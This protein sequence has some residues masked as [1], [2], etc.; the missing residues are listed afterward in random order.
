MYEYLQEMCCNIDQN[1]QPF[2]PH[3]AVTITALAESGRK[4][5]PLEEAKAANIYIYFLL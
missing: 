1:S 2:Q 4:F 5:M 3:G